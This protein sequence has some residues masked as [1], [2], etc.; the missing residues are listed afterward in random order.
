ML[1]GG[2]GHQKAGPDSLANIAPKANHPP[3][4]I[5]DYLRPHGASHPPP[6]RPSD[7]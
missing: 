4:G 2:S 1:G 5:D 6:S 3:V 7:A